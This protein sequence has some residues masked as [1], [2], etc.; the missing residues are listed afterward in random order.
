[1]KSKQKNTIK[2]L[3]YGGPSVGKSSISALVFGKL[4]L[5][6]FNAEIVSEYAKELAWQDKNISDL[7]SQIDIF[8]HQLKK[9]K[10]I[11][12][13]VDFLVSD[14]PLMLN[15]FY[16]KDKFP[17]KIAKENITNNEFHFWLTRDKFKFEEFG[18][19]HNHQE[20]IKIEK[21]MKI[22]MKKNGIKLIE[23]TCPIEERADWIINY[24]LAYNK[25]TV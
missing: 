20:S 19:V 24:I 10:A 1:M 9:E 2:V 25:S 13:K 14:S 8:I 16:S 6:G 12:G 17:L 5:K 15:A 22:F 18:R 23:V 11:M 21:D 4:K 7:F 3:L